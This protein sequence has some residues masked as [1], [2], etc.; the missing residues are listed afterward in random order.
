[1]VLELNGGPIKAICMA[2][3]ISVSLSLSL[4][5][6]SLSIS[7]IFPTEVELA[8]AAGVRRSSRVQR[9]P[10]TGISCNNVD[11]GFLYGRQFDCRRGAGLQMPRLKMMMNRD[12]EEEEVYAWNSFAMV[13][14]YRCLVYFTGWR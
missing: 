10:V 7:I 4:L 8:S 13:T 5:V 11:I 1:M 3:P 14:D 12:E 6:I 9:L 2:L